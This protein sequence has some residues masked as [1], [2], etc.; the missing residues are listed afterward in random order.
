M[1][2][3]PIQSVPIRCQ[4][5]KLTISAFGAP[6]LS[7]SCYCTSCQTAGHLFSKHLHIQS[8][9]SADGGTHYV[10][11]RKD[12]VDYAPAISSLWAF[13][14]NEKTKTRRV[15]SSCCNTPLFLELGN[16]HWL[17]VY[18]HVLPPDS[19]PSPSLRTMISDVPGQSFNDDMPSYSSQSPGFMFRL[20][21]AWIQMGFR[22]PKLI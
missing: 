17:S 21:W 3:K 22:A 19:R 13:R 14:L 11:Y 12:R 4:C 7:A 5:G 2:D 16:G 6:I 9:Q 18:A 1:S 20:L 15:L 8:P 10:L